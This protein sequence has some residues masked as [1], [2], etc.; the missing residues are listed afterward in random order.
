MKNLIITIL[1]ISTLFNPAFAEDFML[2]SFS[3]KKNMT[4]KFSLG[5]V[6]FTAV[7]LKDL[8]KK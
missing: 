1:L 7:H 4:S 8:P 5:V 2:G 6:I 3:E